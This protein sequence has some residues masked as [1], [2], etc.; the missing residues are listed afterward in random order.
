MKMPCRAAFSVGIILF[1]A[2]PAA[3]EVVRFEIRTR[4][5]VGTSGYEK[6]IATARISVDPANAHNRAIADIDVVPLGTT[7]RIDFSTD[8]MILEPIDEAKSNSVAVLE[9]PNRG[10]PLILQHM[11][12]AP[13]RFDFVSNADLGDGFLM[14]RGF[15]VVWVGWQFDVPRDGRLIGADLPRVPEVQGTVEADFTPNDN[16]PSFTVADLAGYPPLDA[17]GADT[18]LTV[19]DGAF[20]VT[21][22]IERGRYELRGN[23]ISLAGGFEK[24]RTY[25]LRYRS[26]N[27]A[28]TGLGLA[29]VRDVASWLRHSPEAPVHPRFIY[30]YGVSQS[31]RFMREFMKAGFNRDERDLQVF[32]A[33]MPVGAGAAR[34]DVNRR[35]ALPNGNQ[36]FEAATFP[37]ADQRLRDPRTRREEGLLD[38]DPTVKVFHIN[39]GFEYWGAGRS[40]ALTHTTPDGKG[41]I[42]LPNSSRSYYFAGT[43]H[44]PGP[45]PPQIQTGAHPSNF[46]GYPLRAMLVALDQWTRQ[47][48]QPPPSAYPRFADQTLIAADRIAFPAIPGTRPPL[49]IEHARADGE[50]LPLLVSQIDADGNDR[51]GIRLPLVTVPLGTY[52]GWNFRNANVGGGAELFPFIGSFVPF[53][54]TG[55][56]GKASGDPRIAVSERYESREHYL[57]MFR[58][59]TDASISARV[60]V[61]EDRGWMTLQAERLW[62][63][64]MSK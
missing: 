53:A 30:G 56:Q 3:G 23:V 27:P 45:F 64:V 55:D 20:G 46:A 2:A 29:A 43:A 63:I 31:G 7:G 12:R 25:R 22:I 26:A 6:I 36:F 50:S 10:Y 47:G 16:A 8:V 19:R 57:S 17:N 5:P 37:F 62:D 9:A 24:G 14:A 35:W 42:E 11:N 60:L 34:L 41:D 51:A 18:S 44:A 54:A 1:L 15:T 13:G 32:D 39:S 48:I 61:E 28:I 58:A 33:V 59:A 49:G 52:T 40:A 4:A 38:T 21:T